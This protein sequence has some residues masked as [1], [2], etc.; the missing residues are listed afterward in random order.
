PPAPVPVPRQLVH[1][2]GDA[3]GI[4]SCHGLGELRDR[5]LD[6][7]FLP[8]ERRLAEPDDADVGG[9]THDDE[10]GS[11]EVDKE[12][13]D[14]SDLHVVDQPLTAPAVMPATTYFCANR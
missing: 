4:Q 8:L 1:G 11:I 12:G 5:T 13:V 14:R 10:V 3:C 6:R 7:A 2:P 9:D